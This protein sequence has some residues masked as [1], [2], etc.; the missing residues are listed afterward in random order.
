MEVSSRTSIVD[1]PPPPPPSP[2]PQPCLLFALGDALNRR[3]S[4]VSMFTYRYLCG[5][6][7]PRN[8]PGPARPLE[9][10]RPKVPRMLEH[11]RN[12]QLIPMP[13][14]PTS[15][16]QHGINRRIV[17]QFRPASAIATPL[18]HDAARLRSALSAY[19]HLATN[20]PPQPHMPT[21]CAQAS[22]RTNM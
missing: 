8:A 22:L 7:S 16:S 11:G 12:E 4:H 1:P 10:M 9:D 15:A 20:Q 3:Q 18:V 21:Q 17:C 6:A 5:K 19:L 13:S 2:S 14:L